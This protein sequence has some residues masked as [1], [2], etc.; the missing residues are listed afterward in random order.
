MVLIGDIDR[1]GVIAQIVGTRAVLDPE[2]AAM[3][4]GFIV[5]KFRG[6]A[7]LFDAGMRQI[8]ERSGW[9]SFG[10]VPILRRPG[11]CRRKTRWRS[12]IPREKTAE[13]SSWWFR[14][15]RTSPISTI[16]TR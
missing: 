10:L 13:R 9:P 1:G 8:V 15:C 4:A 16:S 2:D 12:T 11:G 6:D 5:N 3:I 7:S 14:T